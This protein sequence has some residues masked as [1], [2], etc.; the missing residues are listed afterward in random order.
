MGVRD[1]FLSP[2]M[3]AF[4]FDTMT[5]AR[6]RILFVQLSLYVRQR[7]TFWPQV[8]ANCPEFEVKQRIMEHEH[9]ELVGTNF[10]S[11]PFGSHLPAG[12]RIALSVDDVSRLSRCRLPRRRS[13]AGF[14]SRASAWQEA[15]AA[16][17]HRGVDE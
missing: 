9:E 12:Q 10:E 8:A 4:L 6:A 3:Q 13:T 2:E 11:R 17:D 1:L 7:E 16:S 14:G 5:T 15:I